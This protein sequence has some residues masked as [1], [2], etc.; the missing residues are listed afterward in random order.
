MSR[1]FTKD[2]LDIKNTL[3]K[4]I[5]TLVLCYEV[6]NVATFWVY[7]DISDLDPNI[8]FADDQPAFFD[9]ISEYMEAIKQYQRKA[10]AN[11]R[12]AASLTNGQEIILHQMGDFG[13]QEES[14][15]T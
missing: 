15:K 11:V 4:K 12:L 3:D 6:A 9:A 5:D 13:R 7:S 8:G 2:L 14:D 10:Y 1:D